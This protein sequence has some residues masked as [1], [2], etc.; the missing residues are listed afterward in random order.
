MALL[1]LGIESNRD[2]RA[3]TGTDAHAVS[4]R[5]H[6]SSTAVTG[7]ASRSAT[8][9]QTFSIGERSE[10]RAGQNSVSYQERFVHYR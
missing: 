10:E 9:Y 5:C 4:T 2:W 3:C 7:P 6:R 1:R 8:M